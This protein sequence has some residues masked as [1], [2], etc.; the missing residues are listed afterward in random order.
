MGPIKPWF[1]VYAITNQLAALVS[2]HTVPKNGDS[3]GQVV[4][5]EL[6]L[7]GKL[8][9]LPSLKALAELDRGNLATY[10][11]SL[12]DS[13]DHFHDRD[14]FFIPLADSPNFSGYKNFTICGLLLQAVEGGVGLQRAF[15]RVGFAVISNVDGNVADS[16][17]HL[18]NWIPPPWP[19]EV[20]QHVVIV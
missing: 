11:F 9:H 20:L 10:T 1:T 3:F 7:K 8:F 18:E 6:V 15:Q 12:D 16:G 5:G 2:F 13:G 19:E 14:T 17:Y 4:G